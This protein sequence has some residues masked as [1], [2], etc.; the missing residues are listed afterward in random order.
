MTAYMQCFC[1]C[2]R[3]R[4]FLCVSMFFVFV[5]LCV[6]PV[7]LGIGARSQK[8]RIMGLPGRQRS[9]TITSAVWIE[10]INVTD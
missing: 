8:T 1:K 7:E 2:V 10:C 3:F 9:L 5:F 4:F 6:F